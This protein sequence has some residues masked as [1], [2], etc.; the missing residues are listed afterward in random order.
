MRVG[1]V[2]PWCV[3]DARLLLNKMHR[4]RS[5]GGGGRRR[6]PF[7]SKRWSGTFGALLL[8]AQ[9]VDPSVRTH[10]NL[11]SIGPLTPARNGMLW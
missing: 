9:S 4:D 5:D 11:S 3:E 7:P 6:S 1:L 8:G 10:P 2:V